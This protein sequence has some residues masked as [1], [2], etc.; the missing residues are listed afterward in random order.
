V[1]VGTRNPGGPAFNQCFVKF[2]ILLNIY[3]SNACTAYVPVKITEAILS[4]AM[5]TTLS[6]SQCYHKCH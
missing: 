5:I 4:G 2:Y 1:A 3:I 6:L